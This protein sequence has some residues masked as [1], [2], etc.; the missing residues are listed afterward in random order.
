ML[1][2]NATSC[3]PD[4]NDWLANSRHPRILHVI[5]RACNL[6]NERRDVFFPIILSRL[7]SYQESSNGNYL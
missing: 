2:I 4:V 5:D 3:A 7:I 6:I 1:Y